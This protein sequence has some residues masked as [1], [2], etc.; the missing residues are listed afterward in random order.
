MGRRQFS[1]EPEARWLTEAR[2][3]RDMV[4]LE[5]FWFIDAKGRR[6]DAPKGS[7]VN[8]ASIPRPLWTLVGSPYT[9]DYRRATI[10]HDIACEAAVGD[11]DLRRTADRM[12]FE[13]CREGG[14]SLWDA[15][16][17]YVGV[18]IGSWRNGIARFDESAVRLTEEPGTAD[19]QRDF[20]IVSEDVLR[21]GLSD[22]PEDVEARTDAALAT[23]VIRKAQLLA[24]NNG[25]TPPSA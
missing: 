9:G 19:L 11:D 22:D 21:Q 4:L 15:T 12:F 6:W 17:L 8:G 25:A 2:A 20:R 1:G 13:A 23:Y 7:Q 18:R 24:L 10:V 3:D 5:D 16:V 14:C